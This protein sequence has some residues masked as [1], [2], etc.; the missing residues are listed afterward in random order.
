M[1]NISIKVHYEGYLTE[2]K[3]VDIFCNQLKK[4]IKADKQ[5]KI[6]NTR[7]KADIVIND[8]YMIEFDGPQH[9][10]SSHQLVS[11]STKDAIWE[12]SKEGNEVIRIPYFV[13]LT[14]E[15]FNFYFH[16]IFNNYIIEVC[17]N[18]PHGF[19]DNKVILP[20]DFCSYGERRFIFELEKL[21]PSI[22]E[23]IIQ[24][25]INKARVEKECLEVFSLN[26]Q[27]FPVFQQYIDF[28]N[29]DE[30]YNSIS[31]IHKII[32]NQKKKE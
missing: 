28:I 24:S 3:L 18:F 19:I 5:V 31:P 27:E 8:T 11:D 15:T 13:Q 4:Y 7:Y 25:M 16:T 26:I 23:N 12:L 32:K 20:A 29:L 6:S 17:Q 9:Y 30:I 10:T 1:E 22:T 14:T 2:Q 21:P